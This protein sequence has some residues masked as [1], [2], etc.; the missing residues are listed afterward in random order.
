[1]QRA[2]IGCHERSK[3]A[4]LLA[5]AP[6]ALKGACP[7]RV[8]AGMKPT[9]ERQQGASFDLHRDNLGSRKSAKRLWARMPVAYRQHATFYTDQYSASW[10][11]KPITS[12]GSTPPCVSALHGGSAKRCR[13]PRSS[14]IISGPSRC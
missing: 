7:V 14:P 6:D 12:S 8:G 1:M 5:G 13:F 11:A 10:P 4:K 3:G 2:A 9:A